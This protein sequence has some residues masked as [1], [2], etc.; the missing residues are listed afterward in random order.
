MKYFGHKNFKPFGRFNLNQSTSNISE[1]PVIKYDQTQPTIVQWS[2]NPLLWYHSISHKLLFKHFKLLVIDRQKVNP[3]Q[4]LNF[5]KQVKPNQFDIRTATL[6]NLY[7]KQYDFGLV[8][9][10][11]SI[12]EATF[13]EYY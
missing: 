5:L 7:A 12:S 2:T 8:N 1:Q 4:L 11:K 10:D 9:W 13:K 6:S 3:T